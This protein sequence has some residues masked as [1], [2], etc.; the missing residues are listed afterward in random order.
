MNSLEYRHPVAHPWLGKLLRLDQ[1]NWSSLLCI[2][3][4]VLLK[5]KN[6]NKFLDVND[7]GVCFEMG[8]KLLNAAQYDSS[9]W[10]DHT[11]RWI[12]HKHT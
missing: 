3:I 7:M 2:N 11:G 4:L 10:K 9:L 8:K 5:D 1:I 6:V 12:P